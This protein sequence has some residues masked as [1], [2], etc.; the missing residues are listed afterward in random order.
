MSFLLLSGVL[1]EIV[2][3]SG[4]SS[5]SSFVS[6]SYGDSLSG[7]SGD[8]DLI[9]LWV[10]L[11]RELLPVLAP[12]EDLLWDICEFLYEIFYEFL[13][14]YLTDSLFLDDDKGS[15]KEPSIQADLSLEPIGDPLDLRLL[16][17]GQ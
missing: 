8:S 10:D 9:D 7:C 3:Y 6:C 12:Y 11:L 17:F 15:P 5:S 4:I 1:G 2:S 16:V 14:D 13:W